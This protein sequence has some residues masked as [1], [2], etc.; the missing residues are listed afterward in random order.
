M[1]FSF[2]S[3]EGGGS[4][5]KVKR[6][7]VVLYNRRC[8]SSDE[9][10]VLPANRRVSFSLTQNLCFFGSEPIL[11]MRTSHVLGPVAGL[12]QACCNRK[13][14]VLP[15]RDAPK[16]VAQQ[17][18]GENDDHTHNGACLQRCAVCM[19]IMYGLCLLCHYRSRF[20]TR[21]HL[22]GCLGCCLICWS[23]IINTSTGT[24]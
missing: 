18:A 16:E 14:E 23:G 22:R 17:H 11:H 15:D 21:P 8:G 20:V 4:E 19:Y 10:A 9:L 2:D 3:D 24:G 5:L 1:E 12:L 6:R 7:A 13:L